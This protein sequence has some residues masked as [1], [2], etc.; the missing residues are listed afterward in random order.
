VGKACKPFPE[1]QL[2][3]KDTFASVAVGKLKPE[4]GRLMRR[5]KSEFSVKR[6]LFEKKRL[7]TIEAVPL[8]G[9]KSTSFVVKRS[10]STPKM[11]QLQI[12]LATDS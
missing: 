1:R 8:L 3:C 6:N 11:S 9:I 10:L 12:I 2:S 5:K 4:S 7:L